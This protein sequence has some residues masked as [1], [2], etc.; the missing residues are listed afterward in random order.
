MHYARSK[1]K[2]SEDKQAEIKA[3]NASLPW[4]ARCWNCHTWNE[5]PREQLTKCISCG[6]NLWK[7][8]ETR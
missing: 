3:A 7:R 1:R 6:V 8:D 5:A 2:M 4:R